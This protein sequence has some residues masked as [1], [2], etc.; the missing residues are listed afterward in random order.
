M[1]FMKNKLVWSLLLTF[2]LFSCSDDNAVDDGVDGDGISAGLQNE[3]NEFVWRGLNLYYYWVDDVEDLSVDK[4]PFLSDLYGFLNQY[5]DPNDLF[6]DLLIDGDEFSFMVEDYLVLE[7]SFQGVSKSY[8]FNPG[9]VRVSQ[10][11][12]ELLAYVR[13]VTPDG[14]AT[15]AGLKRGDIITEIDGQTLTESNFVDLLLTSESMTI[16]LSEV[17][18]NTLVLTG[19]EISLTAVEL[20]ENPILLSDVLDAGGTKVGY[21]MY[22]QFVN[23]SAAIE[24]L[25]DVFGTF[26]AEGIN[27]LVLDLR[28]NP[29]GS[30]NTSV[31]LGS[32]IYGGGNNN[33]V[34]GL[35]RYNEQVENALIDSGIDLN[36]YFTD[37][38]LGTD[39]PLNR[40][41]VSR[42]FILTSSNTA[43]ASELVISG[44]DPYIDVTLIGTKT[45]GKN[46]GSATFYDSPNY[47]KTPANSTNN[48]TFSRY[49]IQPIISRWTNVNDLDYGSGFTP[50]IQVNEVDFLGSLPPLGD[51]ADPLLAEA[52]AIIS[53]GVAR[54]E[55]PSDNGMRVLHTEKLINGLL[56]ED[57]EVKRVLV[58]MSTN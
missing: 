51:T 20:V 45:V 30:V 46:L 4:Y 54:R 56:V 31:I 28:Y 16:G 9:I 35:S 15:A 8:G 49:A 37:V 10:G 44:L 38:I 11:S 47:E 50:D 2:A 36:R 33:T 3:V 17:Q 52:L 29:G 7:Q 43:S 53:G 27:D 6:N 40:L 24:E 25:N 19:Q 5:D 42:V 55:L 21:L 41:S 48:H 14:P 32:L 13:Y 18:N 34:Y 26:K 39:V 22:N 57:E 1:E 23:N 12:P 58:E